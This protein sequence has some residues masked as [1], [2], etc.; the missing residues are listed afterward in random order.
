M[1]QQNDVGY[2][3][4]HGGRKIRFYPR[5]RRVVGDQ[6]SRHE[7]PFSSGRNYRRPPMKALV[8][9]TTTAAMFALA[10]LAY[11]QTATSTAPGANPEF[12]TAG[13]PLNVPTLQQQ[14]AKTPDPSANP[15]FP[16]AGAP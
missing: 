7:A 9:S 4:R 3:N 1:N 2:F 5:R 16:T 8:L 12:P 6:V 15:H 13:A 10:T 14:L 11:G